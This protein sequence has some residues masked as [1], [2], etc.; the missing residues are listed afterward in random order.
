MQQVIDQ[1]LFLIV[2][3]G[4]PVQSALASP[5]FDSRAITL[6]GP[7]QVRRR[8]QEALESL[9]TSLRGKLVERLN[10]LVHAR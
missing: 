6:N 5:G 3:E 2:S 10:N 7:L 1:L 9:T 4:V 8:W